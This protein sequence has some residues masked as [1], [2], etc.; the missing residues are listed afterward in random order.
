MFR[1]GIYE[2]MDDDDGGPR[3][4]SEPGFW[5]MDGV[6]VEIQNPA[7]VGIVVS[8]LEQDNGVPEQYQE[9]VNLRAGLSLASSAGAPTPRARAA[10]LATDIGNVLNGVDLP[11]PFALD[12]HIGTQQL[13]LDGSI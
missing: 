13:A 6:P 10:R 1:Y 5:G 7:D 11:I 12:D 4:V 3:V 2:D 8:L 9:L